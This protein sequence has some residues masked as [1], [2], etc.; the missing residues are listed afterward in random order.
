MAAVSV[1]LSFVPFQI[2]G[3]TRRYL[4]RGNFMRVKKGE[5]Q[6]NVNVRGF[7]WILS[8]DYVV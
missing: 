5:V 8:L 6:M 1:F 2:L 7:C 3:R 4:S